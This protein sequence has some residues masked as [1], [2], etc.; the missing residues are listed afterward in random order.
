MIRIPT[1]LW[2]LLGTT[3]SAQPPTALYLRGY[4]VIPTPQKVELRKGDVTLDASWSI[5]TS[6]IPANHIA[7]RALA[8]DLAEFH[9]LRLSNGARKIR[10]AVQK[11]AVAGVED[12]ELRSQAYRL[13]IAADRIDIT[14]N[15]DSGLF[16]GVQTLLQLVKEGSG[17]KLLLPE[18]AIEDWPKLQLRFLHWD[19][20]NHQNRMETL[21]RYL[22]WSARFKVNAIGF[23]L[24]DKFEYPSNPVIGAP[25]AFTT[26]ELQEIVNYGLER[27]I[28]VVPVI[29]APAHFSYVLKHP[30]FARLRADGN[31]YQASLCNEDTYK[32]IFQMYDDVINATKGVSYFFVSTDEVYYAGIEATC[33]PY[34]PSTRSQKLAE[35]DRRAHDHLAAR[36]R[37]MLAWLEFPLLAKDLATV[38]SNVIDGVM[39]DASF[40]SVEQ[41]KGMRQLL[42]TSFQGS[43]FL[44]PDYLMGAADTDLPPPGADDPFEFERGSPVGRI[45]GAFREILDNRVWKANPIGLFGAAWDDSGLH[46]EAFWLGW[47]AAAQYAW[48]PGTTGA[49][50]HTAEFMQVYYGPHAD[51]MI[52][53]YRSLQVQARGWQR[54]W[55]R[56]VSRTRSAG[57]GNS[58]GKGI[59]TTRYDQ[60]LTLPPIP[61]LPKLALEP[62]FVKGHQRF[63]KMAQ[64]HRLE[65]DRL[66]N[67]LTDQIGRADRN[68]YSLEV[69]ASLSRFIGHHWQMLL[70][71]AEAERSLE[72]AQMAA[73]S[74]KSK[75]AL[76]HLEAACRQ[77]E[78]TAKDG[79]LVF[80]QLTA[81]FE[82][83][84]YPKGQSAGGRNFVHV[85][86]DTK[87]HF[88]ARTADLSYMFAA[89]RNA[90][91]AQYAAKL[92]ELASAYSKANP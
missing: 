14:G 13:M 91:L 54:A 84:R 53:I 1:L 9:G 88:A 47:S 27:F 6:G 70:A 61:T 35:F 7:A 8:N 65:N 56:V 83:S 51:G 41:Q 21:K 17:G 18:A 92:R 46:D 89:E 49:E 73:K 68:R 3:L 29:Q 24:E 15:S 66:T 74:G 55:D 2:L 11:D 50:Q 44:F 34:N 90:G 76:N 43:E 58:E 79:D 33:G 60:T 4:S 69:L 22:D 63:L 36:G 38:P 78:A 42:Y 23:E 10:L 28:Q 86:D 64:D 19:T 75:D 37:R 81:T 67:A 82:K 48:N 40:L 39:G 16:Y 62:S 32:L 85:L 26:A 59:G 57:Y 31:N 87:D 45:A 25:G 30:Q 77:V 71:L 52:E 20:K 80:Q 72:S 5:T 12:T